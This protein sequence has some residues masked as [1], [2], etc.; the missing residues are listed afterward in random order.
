MMKSTVGASET[1]LIEPMRVYVLWASSLAKVE[2]PGRRLAHA[3]RDQLDVLGM[4]RDGVGFR[5]PVRQRSN[6]WRPTKYPRRIELSAARSNVVIVVE[7]DVMQGRRNEWNEYV[8]E[9]AAR[10]DARDG[11]DLLLP[12]TAFQGNSLPALAGRQLQSIRRSAPEGDEAAWPGWLRHVMM[13][14]MG[15]IWVHQRTLRLKRSQTGPIPSPEEI[16]RITVFLSHAKKDGDEAARL[17]KR[18]KNSA[19]SRRG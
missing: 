11:A 18:L 19:P 5:I 10:M 9:L 12:V 14:A 17:I 1:M 16:R 13:Y 2:D 6:R 7:D 4:V 8:A 3:L 15:S